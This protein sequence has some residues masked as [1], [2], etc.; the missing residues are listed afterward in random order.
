MIVVLH[1]PNIHTYI[2]T[3]IHTVVA[4]FENALFFD[5][6]LLS[7]VHLVLEHLQ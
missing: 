4:K 2:H 7:S 1:L 5:Q 3:Y 6:N